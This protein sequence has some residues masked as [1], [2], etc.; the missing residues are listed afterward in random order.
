MIDE[1]VNFVGI[2]FALMECLL[3]YHQVSIS[4]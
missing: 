1:A 3:F 4:S 2:Y